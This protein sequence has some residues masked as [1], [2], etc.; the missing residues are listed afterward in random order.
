[1]SPSL[2]IRRAFRDASIGSESALGG[3]VGGIVGVEG[4]VVE[5]VGGRRE[6]NSERSINGEK[7]KR[8]VV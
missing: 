8:K 2:K 1:M 5:E 6:R 4:A 3:D 7:T